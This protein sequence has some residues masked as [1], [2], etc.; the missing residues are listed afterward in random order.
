MNTLRKITLVGVCAVA[1]PLVGIQSPVAADVGAPAPVSPTPPTAQ[2]VCEP[3]DGS[4]ADLVTIPADGAF[5]YTIDGVPSPAG[6][7]P[8]VLVEHVVEAVPNVDVQVADGAVVVWTLRFTKVPCAQPEPPV[9]W[10]SKE[11]ACLSGVM[12]IGH[13][14]LGHGL[15]R[16]GG[17]V[18]MEDTTPAA[19]RA[20]NGLGA[21]G[22]ETDWWSSS[23][24]R[25]YS[26][27]DSTLQ[28]T[29]NGWGSVSHRSSRYMGRLDHPGASGFVHVATFRTDSEADRSHT[30]CFRQHELKPGGFSV[31]QSRR[32]IDK[33]LATTKSPRCTLFTSSQLSTVQRMNKLDPRFPVGWI[34]YS[35]TARFDLSKVPAWVDVLMLDR[36]ALSADYVERAVADGHAV[37]ARSVTSRAQA[38]KL[39]R[40]GVTRIVTDVPWTLGHF[41]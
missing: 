12:V 2:D 6:T 35:S 33:L 9:A 39:K 10:N 11:L 32:M 27:H 20:V 34:N 7:Y 5:G 23:D 36:R 29:T 19:S 30:S 31:V 26:N 13:R 41:R 17:K 21:C 24:G 8:A 40:W 1:L 28:R 25:L 37:S 4:A 38:S 15:T 16:S 22:Y 18:Y 14:S 3:A